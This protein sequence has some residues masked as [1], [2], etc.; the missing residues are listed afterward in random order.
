VGKKV[1]FTFLVMFILSLVLFLSVVSAQ[2]PCDSLGNCGLISQDETDL[3]SSLCTINGDLRK[4][5]ATD[6]N[7]K[8]IIFN[9]CQDAEYISDGLDWIGC[10]S[11]PYIIPVGGR[12]YLCVADQ[13]VGVDSNDIIQGFGTES[14]IECCGDVDDIGLCNSVSGGDRLV[15]G[16]SKSVSGSPARISSSCAGDKL[17]IGVDASGNILCNDTIIFLVGNQKS[18]IDCIDDGGIIEDIDQGQICKFS[19][20]V[21]P[22]DW[23]QFETFAT[24]Q[25]KTCPAGRYSG[26][27]GHSFGTISCTYGIYAGCNGGVSGT[28]NYGNLC[29]P[30][31]PMPEITVDNVEFSNQGELPVREY[32]EAFGQDCG[33]ACGPEHCA[34]HF[35]WCEASVSEVGCH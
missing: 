13:V 2:P 19:G 21:C 9:S 35:V 15:M 31:R 14:V 7:F 20:D 1:V 11:G 6:D 18:I 25:G 8:N 23:T 10:F 26:T 29:D 30:N 12:E 34:I 5:E 28:F 3:V 17:L 16:Q 24:I 27:S 4:V 33:P 32:G 22:G